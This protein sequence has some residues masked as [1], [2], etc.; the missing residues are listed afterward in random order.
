MKE[1]F[2]KCCQLYTCVTLLI[3]N[4]S[5]LSVVSWKFSQAFQITFFGRV[6]CLFGVNHMNVDKISFKIIL[7]S[8]YINHKHSIQIFCGMLDCRMEVPQFFS[9]REVIR[10]LQLKGSLDMLLL[11]NLKH[12][13]SVL[14]KTDNLITDSTQELPFIEN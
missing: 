12:C 2:Q 5:F 3:K 4:S 10:L 8:E 11:F 13:Y 1:Q 7:N 9:I 6:I 14:F